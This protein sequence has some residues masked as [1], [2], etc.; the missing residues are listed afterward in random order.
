[1]I[2]R[3]EMYVVN[4]MVVLNEN[5]ELQ[6]VA[7]LKSIFNNKQRFLELWERIQ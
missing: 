1:M 7:V 3:E 4:Q 5:P 2:L 6:S